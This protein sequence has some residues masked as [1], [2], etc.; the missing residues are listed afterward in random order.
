MH[1]NLI[2][3]SRASLSQVCS[4]CGKFYMNKAEILSPTF[5]LSL[6]L[7]LPSATHHLSPRRSLDLG[8]VLPMAR[9]HTFAAASE[10]TLTTSTNKMLQRAIFDVLYPEKNA[11]FAPSRRER[12]IIMFTN[13]LLMPNH[14][15]LY[16]YNN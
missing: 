10:V 13:V 11:L 3:L 16:S 8:P 6:R 2:D 14:D 15:I 5:L 9:P 4:L 12:K 1:N 7:L